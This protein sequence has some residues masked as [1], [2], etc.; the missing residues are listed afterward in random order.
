MDFYITLFNTIYLDEKF[1]ILNQFFCLFYEGDVEAFVKALQN[2]K[3]S[4]SGDEEKKKDEDD[5]MALD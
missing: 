3:K 5:G 4:P 1:F 2:N